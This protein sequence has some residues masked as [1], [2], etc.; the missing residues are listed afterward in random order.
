M[1]IHLFGASTPTGDY[2]KKFAVSKLSDLNIICYS[3]RYDPLNSD[4]VFLDLSSNS[5]QNLVVSP[6]E[7][8]VIVSFVPLWLLID[9]LKR[10]FQYASSWLSNIAAVIVCSS[11][12]VL[13]KRFS[14]NTSDRLLISTLKQSEEDLSSI[15]SQLNIPLM[16]LQPSLIYG[17]SEHFQDRNLTILIKLMRL[18]PFLPLPANSGLRQP[19]HASQ[20]ASV[21]VEMISK[22]YNSNWDPSL[23]ESLILG[24]DSTISYESM[25]RLL[26]HALPNNDSARQCRL[27]LIPNRIFFLLAIP[28]L[29]VSPKK[30]E[31]VVRMC[32][33]LSGYSSVSKILRTDSLSFPVS[34]FI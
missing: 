6:E 18:F 26:Q 7:P 30:F 13:A 25:I 21:A 9:F 17:V 20:L 24:G 16:I 22:F 23:S 19:I 29:F 3:S 2:F 1:K 27:L 14:F 34:P 31:A 15:C 12:S 5:S 11:S 32:S 4:V 33:N 8:N 28:L 10:E